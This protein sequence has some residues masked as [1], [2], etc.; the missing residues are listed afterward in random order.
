MLRCDEQLVGNQD[1]MSIR[2]TLGI[3]EEVPL[4]YIDI[5][6]FHQEMRT[7][8]YA[9]SFARKGSGVGSRVWLGAHSRCGVLPGVL[10]AV[11]RT[12]YELGHLAAYILES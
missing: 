8:A 10:A 11:R 5:A 12:L 7:D 9:G 2:G 3:L 1:T 4:V 6:I